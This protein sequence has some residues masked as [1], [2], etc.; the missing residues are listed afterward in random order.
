MKTK[1]SLGAVLLVSAMVPSAV[2]AQEINVVTTLTTYASIAREILGEQ[3][4]ATAISRGDEDAHFV[5][6]KPSFVRLIRDADL[7]VTTGMDLELWVPALLDR[8]GNRD[9]LPGGPAYVSASVGIDIMEIPSSVDRSQG[10]IHIFGNPHLL[11][12][13]FNAIVVARNITGGLKRI[14]PEHSGEFDTRL[15]DFERRLL[16]AMIG[17]ELVEALTPASVA[18]L[19]AQ[20]RLLEFLSSTNLQGRPLSE[21]LSGWMAQASVLRGK[22]MVCYHREW[23]YFSRRFGIP[24]AGY[25][26]PKLGIPPTPGHVRDLIDLMRRES[27]PAIFAAN[28]YPLNQ[29]D[30][31]AGRTGAEAVIVAEHTEGEPGVVTYFDLVDHWINSLTEAYR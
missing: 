13:P 11:S 1:S 18:D 23:S 15:A 24:C 26:E 8:A 17:P 4:S 29:I 3:G 6:P 2:P 25:V 28:Y 31:V 9:V 12:D 22:N 5:Q 19:M 27:I 16:V 14:S 20:G 30:Q 21:R 7:F 10:D